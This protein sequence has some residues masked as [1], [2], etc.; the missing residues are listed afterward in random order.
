MVGCTSQSDTV[1]SSQH[2]S[3]TAMTI[4]QASLADKSRTAYLHAWTKL[5]KH[6]SENALNPKLPI[7]STDLVNYLSILFD[8]GYAASTI[9]SHNAAIA[10]TH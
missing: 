6:W 9:A 7:S 1:Q 4:I 2:L 10:F 8:Q 5:V 3:I